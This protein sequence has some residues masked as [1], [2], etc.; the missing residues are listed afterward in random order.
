MGAG[1]MTLAS[2]L[3]VLLAATLCGVTVLCV[4]LNY[5]SQTRW[6]RLF[7]EKQGI[8][9]ITMESS[10]KRELVPLKGDTRARIS[11]PI[12]GGQHFQKPH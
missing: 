11:V 3:T 5:K 6:M 1:T 9:G 10:P 8:P 4:V 2:W 7:C 12:P